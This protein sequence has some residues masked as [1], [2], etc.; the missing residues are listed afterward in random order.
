MF[1]YI[2][3]NVHL[4]RYMKLWH[5][6]KIRFYPLLQLR[7]RR[8]KKNYRGL[9]QSCQSVL[10]GSQHLFHIASPHK[11]WYLVHDRLKTSKFGEEEIDSSYSLMIEVSQWEIT[12]QI[13]SCFWVLLVRRNNIMN[14]H[15]QRASLGEI[16]KSWR[17]FRMFFH[18]IFIYIFIEHILFFS[19]ESF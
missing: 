8:I 4:W 9:H 5:P 13:G 18:S 6:V 12:P 14:D 15:E 10:S 16:T 19:I 3:S 1:I 11:D 7:I 17:I 2:F